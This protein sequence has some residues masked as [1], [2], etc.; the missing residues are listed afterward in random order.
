MVAFCDKMK[1]EENLFYCF[2]YFTNIWNAPQH[3][4]I[5]TFEK[6]KLIKTFLVHV[7]RIHCLITCIIDWQQ[8][9]NNLAL[10]R[11][12]EACS[13]QRLPVSGWQLWREVFALSSTDTARAWEQLLQRRYQSSP[14]TSITKR[15]LSHLN[16]LT[17]S[18]WLEY[19]CNQWLS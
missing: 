7:N 2:H 5:L 14:T 9:S 18:L 12:F 11:L 6:N 10:S 17:L 16:I 13:A 15:Y 3:G 8:V 4:I 1:L 19:K